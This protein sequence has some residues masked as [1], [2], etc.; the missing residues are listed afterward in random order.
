MYR[1]VSSVVL[2][3]G[4]K[5]RDIDTKK[6]YTVPQN[7]Y[8]L[9][10]DLDMASGEMGKYAA[11][12]LMNNFMENKGANYIH[13]SPGNAGYVHVPRKVVPILGNGG[14]GNGD[15]LSSLCKESRGKVCIFSD[16]D[17]YHISGP[18][19]SIFTNSLDTHIHNM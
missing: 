11:T 5:V 2:A 10:F 9:Y 17:G 6:T 15:D 4:M 1:Y 13:I 18:N 7:M 12:Q 14:Y 8:G 19:M 3:T 16:G